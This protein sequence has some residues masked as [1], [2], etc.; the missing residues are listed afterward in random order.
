VIG[1]MTIPKPSFPGK[2]CCA[3]NS[4]GSEF[5]YNALK[6]KGI[7]VMLGCPVILVGG[8]GREFG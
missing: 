7:P 6:Q 2:P 5:N 4:N 1:F 8:A 3:E